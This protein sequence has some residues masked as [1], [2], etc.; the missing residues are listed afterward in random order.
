[1]LNPVTAWTPGLLVTYHGSL[2]AL[3]GQYAAYPCTSLNC[4]DER[5]LPGVR[6]ELR[7]KHGAVAVA[8]VRPRSITPA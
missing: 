7:D 3:H 2:T 8:C 4:V 1:M 5:G 6:F